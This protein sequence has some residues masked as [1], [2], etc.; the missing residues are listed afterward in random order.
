[1]IGRTTDATRAPRTR[2]LRGGL[3]VGLVAGA[4]FLGATTIA[5]EQEPAPKAEPKAEDL[6]I[7]AHPGWLDREQP[8]SP[9]GNTYALGQPFFL[10]A[11]PKP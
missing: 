8:Q 7:Q 11:T 10:G 6:N 1:M 4:L 5:A 3:V 9:W 2:L